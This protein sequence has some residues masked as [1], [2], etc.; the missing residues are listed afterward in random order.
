M[1]LASD[2]SGLTV[3]ADDAHGHTDLV[4]VSDSSA[5]VTDRISGS[6]T[7]L[8]V[9]DGRVAVATLTD[10]QSGLAVR[11]AGTWRRTSLGPDIDVRAV[12]LG[13]GIVIAAGNALQAGVPTGAVFLMSKD[14][15]ASWS[16]HR[17]VG[18]EVTGLAVS[19][20]SIYATMVLPGSSARVFR[21]EDE[22][23][24]WTPITGAPASETVPGVAVA[25]STLW[26][27]GD[28]VSRL[29]T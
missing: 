28:E 6:P 25:S 5:R 21:S 16:R 3:L 27:V 9:G 20:E 18:A 10:G 1:A 13:K 26:L 19:G 23:R 8:A 12:C 15:G 24:S 14:D 17:R 4:T 7:R 29:P 11:R 22:L 2:G